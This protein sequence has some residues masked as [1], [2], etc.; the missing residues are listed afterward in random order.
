[1]E[2]D[3]RIL[4]KIGVQSSI[5]TIMLHKIRKKIQLQKLHCYAILTV[6]T[7]IPIYRSS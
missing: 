4:D 6:V 3:E 2:P 1:M 5:N 7:I